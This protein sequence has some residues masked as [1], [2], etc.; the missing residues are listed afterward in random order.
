MHR[1]PRYRPR[2]RARE[3]GL[4][5]HFAHEVRRLYPFFPVIAGRV[6]E[7][8]EW[9]GRRFG[10][11]ERVVLDL[12][13]TNHDPARWRDP[14]RFDPD[15]F[16]DWGGSAYDFIPQGGGEYARGHRC[17]GE[18]PSIALLM[19]AIDLL[20]TGLAYEVPEQDLRFRLDRFPSIPE[21]RFVL[22]AVRRVRGA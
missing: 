17:P 15:R 21:S 6:R 20:A 13:G 9:R 18:N 5:L 14:D 12:H 1:H 10:R 3:P 7:P 2:L 16:R 22:R 19:T 8:F 11:G 4:L